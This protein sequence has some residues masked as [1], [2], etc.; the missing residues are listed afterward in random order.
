MKLSNEKYQNLKKD[1]VISDAIIMINDIMYTVR[2]SLEIYKKFG[3]DLSREEFHEKL[4]ARTSKKERVEKLKK[5]KYDDLEASDAHLELT[6]SLIKHPIYCDFIG[7][8]IENLKEYWLPTFQ[9]RQQMLSE[10]KR[11][12]G[13]NIERDV[14]FEQIVLR[15]INIGVNIVERR[16]DFLYKLFMEYDWD[17]YQTHIEGEIEAEYAD[18][19]KLRDLIKKIDQKAR[20]NLNS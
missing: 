8:D 13:P 11:R 16:I 3:N 9:F 2:N 14:W 6:K 10:N 17:K 4:R 18:E 1:K 5:K 19:P 20:S 15:L 12:I 7:V